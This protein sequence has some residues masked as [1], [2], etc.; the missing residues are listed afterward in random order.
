MHPGGAPPPSSA[1]EGRNGGYLSAHAVIMDRMGRYDD[2]RVPVLESLNTA[3]Q[4]VGAA[5]VKAQT[6][7]QQSILNRVDSVLSWAE[8]LLRGSD[9][10]LLSASRL[11]Q[12]Q[13]ITDELRVAAEAF[14]PES[15]PDL[16]GVDQAADRL[17]DAAASVAHQPIAQ[18]AKEGKE[19]AKSFQRSARQRE[20]AL[21]TEA[22]ALSSNIEDLKSVV[23]Q[24]KSELSSTVESQVAGL[25]TRA[26][27]IEAQ[28]NGVQQAQAQLAEDQTSAFDAAQGKRDA[29]YA[30]WQ[31]EQQRTLDQQREDA[32]TAF[33]D[34]LGNGLKNANELIAEL[35]RKDAAAEELV[36]SISIRGT[37]DRYEKEAQSQAEIADKWRVATVG[38]GLLAGV[39]AGSAAF[40]SD[41]NAAHIAGKL[42]LGLLLAGL[43]GYTARQSA[44]HRRREVNARKL[45]LDLAAFGPFID[46]LPEDMKHEERILLGRRVFAQTDDDHSDPERGTSVTNLL[47]RRNGD[48]G[49]DVSA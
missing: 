38:I 35:E 10:G 21:R 48:A 47:P 30:E 36:G 45:Q 42:V 1:R 44:E 37:A 39:A 23:D 28:L 43:A 18:A 9:V 46:P 3:Q 25:K 6:G 33:E 31:A 7:E 34:A 13:T 19:L 29:S 22:D 12:V 20:R 4:R 40:F 11:S 17:V 49:A 32:K 26:D 15:A 27:E 8:V 5:R 2:R 14:D 16:E 41:Q 24:A